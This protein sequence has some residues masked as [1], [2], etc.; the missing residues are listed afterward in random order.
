MRIPAYIINLKNR[1]D[2][3]AHILKEFAGY[4]EF[5]INI[6]EAVYNKKGYVGLW[7]TIRRIIL[8]E[9]NSESPFILICEDDHEFTPAYSRELL[10]NCI[11]EAQR[12]DADVLLGGISWFEDAL[13]VSGQLYWTNRFTGLQFAIIFRKF[14]AKILNSGIGNYNAVDLRL[15]DLSDRLFFAYPFLSV[16]KEFGYSDVTEANKDDGVVRELFVCTTNNLKIMQEVATHYEK[17]SLANLPEDMDY[18]TLKIP[19]YVVNLPERKERLKH[20]ELQFEGKTEFDVKIVDAC[21]HSIG[22]LGLWLTIRKIIS[23]AISN[24]DDVII[25]A[26]DDHVF[27]ENYDAKFLLRNIVEGHWQGVEYL[28]CGTGKFD[29]TVPVSRNRFWT[30]FCLSTQFIVIYKSLFKK[31][32]DA[33]FDEETRADSLL[34]ALTNNKMLLYPS[35]STQLD[36]GYS[37]ATPIHNAQRDLMSLMFKQ[38]D[39]RFNK[40]YNKCIEFSVFK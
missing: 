28:N 38:C 5:S 21:K 15:S 29:V 19:V 17:L 37:D 35:I 6:T 31:I 18:M 23:L 9:V 1:T 7:E 11:E 12:R 4:S 36:F 32:L 34:S 33:P 16:Q 3:K 20:I 30:D 39:E 22:A 8:Q 10:E 26:E 13:Q 2:R 27:T 25:I 24:D 14:F 40:I